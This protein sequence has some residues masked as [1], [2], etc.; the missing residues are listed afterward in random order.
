VVIIICTKVS[1]RTRGARTKLLL[2]Q[3]IRQKYFDLCGR[4]LKEV[5]KSHQRKLVDGSNLTYK[6]AQPFLNP[7]SGSWWIV[8]PYLQPPQ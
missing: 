3:T 7:T 2:A 4:F 1:P 5:T 8:K 6:N